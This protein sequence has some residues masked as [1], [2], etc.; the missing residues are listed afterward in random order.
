MT[1]IAVLILDKMKNRVGLRPDQYTKD[2]L[3]YSTYQPTKYRK[4]K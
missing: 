3:K 4:E 1:I 2:D